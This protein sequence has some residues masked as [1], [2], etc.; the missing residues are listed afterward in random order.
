MA[1]E[2]GVFDLTEELP[3]QL[4]FPA[5]VSDGMNDMKEKGRKYM[6][7]P[8]RREQMTDKKAKKWI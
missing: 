5:F 3:L 8:Q 6:M 2:F 1:T 4:H 7:K